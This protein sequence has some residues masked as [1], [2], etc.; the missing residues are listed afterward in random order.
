MKRYVLRRLLQFPVVLLLASMMIFFI[1]HLPQGDP[2]DLV[3]GVGAS[4]EQI[5]AFKERYHLNEPVYIQYLIWLKGILSGS[6]GTS[7]FTFQPVT[8]M[9][10]ERLPVTFA[11]ASGAILISVSIAFPAGYLS[12]VDQYSW[13]DHAATLFAFL[14]LSIPN[15]FLAILL[16]QVLSLQFG[17]LPITG[18]NIF[19][20][21]L[22]TIRV[23]IM[24][25]IALGTALAAQT[26]RLL[27]SS[28]LD[29]FSQ[30]YVRVARAKGMP[31]KIVN[32]YIVFKNALIPVITIVALQFGFLLG[33]TVVI[34]EVFALPGL[35]RLMLT[36]VLNRDL[37]VMQAT[38]LLF[39][40]VFVT[41]NLLADLLY[42]YIDPRIKYGGEAQ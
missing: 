4:E 33:G 40:F 1:I 20:S 35:G 2:S 3:L 31:Q 29:A 36:S 12:A 7:I 34:E 18:T 28:M 5:Q 30:E 37:P 11:L 32:R 16:I 21:P 10:R 6:L 17:L 9:I 27:R 13:K 39:T 22:Q 42:A 26:T 23:L 8:E 15:F 19:G 41:V 25:V 24:P 14:G 38:V